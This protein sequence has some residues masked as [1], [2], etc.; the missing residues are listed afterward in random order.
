MELC[1][2]TVVVCKRVC[3]VCWDCKNKKIYVSALLDDGAF[4]RWRVKSATLTSPPHPSSPPSQ[5]SLRLYPNNEKTFW[6]N[7]TKR[8]SCD[9]IRLKDDG[10]EVLASSIEIMMIHLL[11]IISRF[12]YWSRFQWEKQMLTSLWLSEIFTW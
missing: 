12:S 6:K 1:T 11:W 10:E 8:T 4:W 5:S 9:K 7:A 2:Y 3:V